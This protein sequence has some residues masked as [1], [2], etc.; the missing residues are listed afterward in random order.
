MMPEEE[1]NG[2]SGRFD[3][4]YAPMMMSMRFHLGL[5]GDEG[6]SDIGSISDF[7]ETRA[8]STCASCGKVLPEGRKRFCLLCK[9]RSYPPSYKC[10]EPIIEER[11]CALDGCDNMFDWSSRASGQKYCSPECG[12]L[13]MKLESKRWL[14]FDRDGFRCNYCGAS[15]LIDEGVR[16]VADHIVPLK[17]GGQGIMANL[18]AKN[19]FART[20]AAFN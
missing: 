18:R 8:R 14:L 11:C 3:R 6:D 17:L 4:R 15:P 1:L 16:L 9:P 2:K 7:G 12:A 19:C 13:S 5:M 20:R 10:R